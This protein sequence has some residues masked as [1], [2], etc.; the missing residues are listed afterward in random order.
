MNNLDYDLP[1]INKALVEYMVHNIPIEQTINECDDLKEF[2]LVT[3]IS[4]KYTHILHG[5]E[6][7]KEKCIRIFASTN[8][9]D[10]GVT[11]IHATTGRPAK[12]SNS[13]EHCFIY[14]DEVNGVKVPKKLD[15]AWY[16]DLAQKRLKDFG[17]I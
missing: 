1:I 7:I 12:I 17:V 15:K 13:P 4:N 3:K 5:D 8:E 9:E 2:Q 11:K 14:N 6:Y 16:V 10:K